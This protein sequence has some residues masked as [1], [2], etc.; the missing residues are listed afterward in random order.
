MLKSSE[1]SVATYAGIRRRLTDLLAD[2]GDAEAASTLVPACPAWSVT[3]VIAHLYGVEADILAGNLAG[4]GTS[5]WA[6][7]QVRRFAP[8]GMHPLLDRWNQVGP[9]V[10][11]LGGAF[12]PQVAAQFVFDASTHEHDIR[13]AL[14]RA[15]AR[16]ADSV[17]VGLTFIE[18]ALHQLIVDRQLPGLEL[19]SPNF[20]A[21]MGAAPT[22]T[23]LSTSTFELFRTFGG[24]RSLGQIHDLPWQGD[25]VPYLELFSTGPLKPPEQ[26][27]IE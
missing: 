17:T 9:D 10:E 22:T 16:D 26:P 5:E 15:G 1:D 13:G 7:E 12:P 24:R 21:T 3:E 14:D 27:L 8:L 4:V 11:A 25:P 19:E 18:A 23:R 20:E 6:D 2:T